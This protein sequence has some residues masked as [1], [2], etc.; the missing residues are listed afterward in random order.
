MALNISLAKCPLI[1]FQLVSRNAI[2]VMWFSRGKAGCFIGKTFMAPDRQCWN[3]ASRC[4][5]SSLI[6]YPHAVPPWT[7]D[8]EQVPTAQRSSRLDIIGPAW[9]LIPTAYNC[10][11]SGVCH[12]AERRNELSGFPVGTRNSMKQSVS[13]CLSTL[14]IPRHF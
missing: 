10:W 6:T 11:S 2:L 13:R 9:K 12:I 8:A 3:Q 14:S 4:C 5:V 1:L 7:S